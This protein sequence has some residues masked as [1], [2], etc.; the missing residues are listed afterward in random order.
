[1][2]CVDAR[3]SLL[4]ASLDTCLQPHSPVAGFAPMLLHLLKDAAA[5]AWPAGD[6]LR[7]IPEDLHRFLDQVQLDPAADAGP[8]EQAWALDVTAAALNFLLFLALREA[9][10]RDI[11]RPLALAANWRAAA[12]M[13]VSGLMTQLAYL[14]GAAADAK[15]SRLAV[16]VATVCGG[17]CRCV[18]VPQSHWS[19]PNASARN[20]R[21]Q[22]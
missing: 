5:A 21:R 1:M 9:R 2:L 3:A 12:A 16:A 14:Q 8:D 15:V 20:S 11:E 19:P 7:R 13:R 18:D 4:L 22:R 6:W 10:D 17:A